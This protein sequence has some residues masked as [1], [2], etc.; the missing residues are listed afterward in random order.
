MLELQFVV[1]HNKNMC[2]VYLYL[3]NFFL[4]Q[5]FTSSFLHKLCQY[6]INKNKRFLF[7]VSHWIVIKK[8]ISLAF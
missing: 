8:C 3:H 4:K 2:K 6:L 1:F 7:L 5:A